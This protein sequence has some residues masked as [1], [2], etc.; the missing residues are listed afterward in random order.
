MNSDDIFGTT[1]HIS[2]AQ[3]CARAALIF[4]FGLALLRVSGRRA[5]AKW[6]ALDVFV[7]VIA[8]SNFS[9]ALTGGAPL[10]GTLAATALL[11]ALHWSLSRLAAYAPLLSRLLE[12]RPIILGED[13]HINRDLLLW[14]GV[15]EQ[16][17]RVALRQKGLEGIDDVRLFVLEPNG[18]FSAIRK[19]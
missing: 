13:A 4:F 17:L 19:G 6:S 1:N 7:S 10:W 16:D 2:L 15:S 5:Y 9:R 14:H 3:E 12:G 18:K 11:M 8:G